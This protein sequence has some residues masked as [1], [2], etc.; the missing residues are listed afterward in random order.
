MLFVCF[1]LSEVCFLYVCGNGWDQKHVLCMFYVCFTLIGSHSLQYDWFPLTNQS[2][3][4]LVQYSTQMRREPRRSKGSNTNRSAQAAALAANDW[5]Q[6]AGG[7]SGRNRPQHWPQRA[8]HSAGHSC[9][10]QH[11]PQRAGHITGHSTGRR[12]GHIAQATAL[13]TAAGSS[14]GYSAQE[15]LPTQ[16][17]MIR[18]HSLRHRYTV[19]H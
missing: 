14:N 8:G 18:S 12:I 6:R 16:F 3:R 2:L 5:P 19:L 9:K 1:F 7:S 13:A 15:L 4:I 11:W 10:K 17:N